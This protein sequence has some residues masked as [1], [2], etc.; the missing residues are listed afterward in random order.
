MVSAAAWRHRAHVT[1]H[2]PAADVVAR[3]NP[4]VYVVTAVDESTCTLDTG[5]DTI[6]S[7]AVHIG[8]LGLDSR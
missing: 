4:A 6:E 7:L 5:A 2:A 1:V 8:L 3:I